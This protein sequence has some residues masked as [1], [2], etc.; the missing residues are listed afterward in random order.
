MKLPHLILIN[1]K[2]KNARELKS[3]ARDNMEG[4]KNPELGNEYCLKEKVKKRNQWKKTDALNK[5]K[6]K[7]PLNCFK[8]KVIE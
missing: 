8:Q 2:R 3:F 1:I 5:I 4:K 7:N 6:K